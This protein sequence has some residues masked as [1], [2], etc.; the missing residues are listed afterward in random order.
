MSCNSSDFTSIS[1][2]D[3]TSSASSS[4]NGCS[5]GATG[6][7]RCCTCSHCSSTKVVVVPAA[8][9]AVYTVIDLSVCPVAVLLAAAVLLVRVA[10]LSCDY[11]YCVLIVS[12]LRTGR[13]GGASVLSQVF[14]QSE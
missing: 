2:S 12:S 5:G 4:S 7:S 13:E 8:V 1:S 3:S 10:V 9:V 6:A 11:Q 14:P